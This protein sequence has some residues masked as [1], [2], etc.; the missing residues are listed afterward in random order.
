MADAPA[1]GM[2]MVNPQT[3]AALLAAIQGLQARGA[4]A[5]PPA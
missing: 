2:L 3:P 1:G 4:S 5:Q